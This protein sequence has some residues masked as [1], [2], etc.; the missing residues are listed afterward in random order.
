MMA[1]FRSNY[2]KHCVRFTAVGIVLLAAGASTTVRAQDDGGDNAF[3][4]WERKVW[5]GFVRGIG[6]QGNEPQIQYR[7][8]SPLVV[9]PTRDLP[10]P[11]AK[12]VP[13]GPEWPVDP[14][15]KRAK[16]RADA[17]KKKRIDGNPFFEQEARQNALTPEQLNPTTGSTR[18]AGGSS[19]P[20][21]GSNGP[22]PIG[23]R[24]LPSDLGYF[25]GLFT[26][27]GLG[28]NRQKTE[29]GTFSH[30]PPRTALT[31]PPIGYQTP[32]GSQPYG[33][34]PRTEYSR[35]QPHDPAN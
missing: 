3:A 12:A 7:E 15:A 5:N 9:P 29:V 24:L 17:K 31:E 25:G 22:E 1:S 16:E 19:A 32:S 34:T 18:P 33:I 14:D 26:W 6:L 11:Q 13:R 27:G 10:P 35:A 8:R 23:N 2:L 28:F 4:R 30:E 21:P 20:V